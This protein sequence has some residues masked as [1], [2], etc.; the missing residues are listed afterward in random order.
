MIM[1]ILQRKIPLFY[2][3]MKN[4]DK[5]EKI[6]TKKEDRRKFL[7]QVIKDWYYKNNGIKTGMLSVNYIK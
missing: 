3:Q 5:F 1:A 6:I 7:K 2:S 4:D